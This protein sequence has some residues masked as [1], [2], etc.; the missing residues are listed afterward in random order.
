M[1][2]GIGRVNRTGYALSYPF[3]G[4]SPAFAY[5]T[6]V[7]TGGGTGAYAGSA[8]ASVAALTGNLYPL[9]SPH[10]L[11]VGTKLGLVGMELL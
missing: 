1:T 3:V 10:R 8:S 6:T 11:M 5:C 7:A 2:F 9:L 4:A